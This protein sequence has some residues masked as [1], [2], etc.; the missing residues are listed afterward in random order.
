MLLNFIVLSDYRLIITFVG[1]PA[2]ILHEHTLRLLYF[3]VGNR[4]QTLCLNSEW[5]LI[6]GSNFDI[7]SM[8]ETLQ[9]NMSVCRPE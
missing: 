6:K 9:L 2:G 8:G 5:S 7:L 4:Q 1:C 3:L